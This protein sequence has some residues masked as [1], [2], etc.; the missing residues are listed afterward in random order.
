MSRASSTFLNFTNYD[1]H[2]A[3]KLIVRLYFPSLFSLYPPTFFYALTLITG[4]L[5]GALTPEER[6]QVMGHRQSSTYE[7]YY[8]PDLIERDFQS[9]YFGTP[10][11]DLLIQSVARMGISRDRRAPTELTEDQKLEVW[12]NLELVQLYKN[13]K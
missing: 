7:Q 1:G 11:Q 10:S 2:Q 13:R 4:N 9:I 6:N 12:N 3:G 8:M 5:L